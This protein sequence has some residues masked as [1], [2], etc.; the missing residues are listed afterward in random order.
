MQI[1]TLLFAT[2]NNRRRDTVFLARVSALAA[3]TA[4]AVA[5]GMAA[6]RY[7]TAAAPLKSVVGLC[8]VPFGLWT[9]WPHLR[10]Q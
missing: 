6:E 2:N 8:F 1:A 7:L 10:S 5:L 4:I 3:S 9:I